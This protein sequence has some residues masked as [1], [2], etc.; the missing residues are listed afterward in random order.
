MTKSPEK[1]SST[2]ILSII[3]LYYN[4][5][6]YLDSC[7]SSLSQLDLGKYAIETIIVNNGSIDG[8]VQDSQKKFSSNKTINPKFVYSPVNLGFSK[9]NNFGLKYSNPKSKYVLFINDDMTFAKD[10]V[11][12]MLDFFESRTEVDAATGYVTLA[13]SGK[14]APE[15][16]RGFPTPWN[17]F[18]HFFGLGIPKLFPKSKILHGYLGDYREY[19][20]PTQIE[21]CQGCFLMLKRQV[22]NAISWWNEKYFFLG[23]DLD[24]CY[25]LKKKNF[26]LF[27]NPAA[28]ITHYHGVSSGL[29]KTK[30]GASRETRIRSALASTTAMRLFY[31]EN[32][33]DQYPLPLHWLI[34][35]GIKLLEI[36]RLLK[37]KY[38]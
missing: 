25:Q 12:Q 4:S 11:K 36:Q 9:G 22:G 2:P 10:A 18:W 15:T 29:Q 1:Y 3:V 5:K 24:L 16:H 33:M 26:N 19:E 32:L 23:E 13:H 28:K 8:I 38:L 21:C 30:S 37:A 7:L 31:Q 20:T 6:T 17:T 34:W 14:L 27:L 35:T